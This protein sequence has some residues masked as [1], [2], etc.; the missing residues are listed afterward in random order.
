MRMEMTANERGRQEEEKKQAGWYGD[1]TE[2]NNKTTDRRWGGEF[3]SIPALF[4]PVVVVAAVVD[5]HPAS[6]R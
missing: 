6:K 4:Q 5:N 2:G 1:G 3:N